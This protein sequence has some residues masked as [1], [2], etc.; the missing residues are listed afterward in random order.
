M[1]RPALGKETVMITLSRRQFLM[2][3]ACALFAP[4]M[5]AAAQTPAFAPKGHRSRQFAQETGSI[6]WVS[7]SADGKRIAAGG[8]QDLIW[9]WDAGTGHLEWKL[10]PVCSEVS[11]FSF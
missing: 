7:W 2:S 5:P 11:M 6:L 9:V 1:S 10:S 3:S 8:V 4:Q